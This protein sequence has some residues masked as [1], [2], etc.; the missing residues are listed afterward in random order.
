M[1]NPSRTFWKHYEIEKYRNTQEG[2]N[3][4]YV[5]LPNEVIKEFCVASIK[6]IKALYAS[7]DVAKQLRC[8]DGIEN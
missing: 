5:N 4:H 1:N 2:E 7:C 3:W 8:E 6:K